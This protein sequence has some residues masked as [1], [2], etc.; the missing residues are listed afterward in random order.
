MEKVTQ[1]RLLI[2]LHRSSVQNDS[3]NTCTKI[4]S[5][6]SLTMRFNISYML[7]YIGRI[8]LVVSTSWASFLPSITMNHT[9]AILLLLFL[10]RGQYTQFFF[11]NCTFNCYGPIQNTTCSLHGLSD[12]VKCDP[13]PQSTTSTHGKFCFCFVFLFCYCFLI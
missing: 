12:Q 2:M 11:L 3:R 6:S 10:K 5:W 9:V 8:Y 1:N 7:S 13:V 4:E